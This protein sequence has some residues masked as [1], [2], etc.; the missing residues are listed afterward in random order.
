MTSQPLRLV[1]LISGHGSNLQAML[2]A[3]SSELSALQ[4]C[5]VIS[6]QPDAYGLQRAHNAAVPTA[7][8]SRSEFRDRESFDRMI[9]ERIDAFGADLV[10]L[11][12]FMRILGTELVTAYRG[13][14]LNIH[15]SL[16]P[17]Y[18][19]LHT[20][21]R[22]LENGDTMHGTSVH[23]VTAE[24]DGGP[25]IAQAEVAIRSDDDP[26]TLSAR[27]Q[28]REHILYPRVINWIGT[29]RLTW[30]GAVPQFDGGPLE[31]PIVWKHQSEP[32]SLP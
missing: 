6:D 25:V 17:R 22:A 32:D 19:G 12:G 2:D 21:R 8:V 20:H 4:I 3:R 16:L 26:V 18:R 11:A 9:G 28:Q 23:F 15:P 31:K 10:V 5:G 27:V 14:M 1:V 30:T 29:G 24:L 7:L 13:R